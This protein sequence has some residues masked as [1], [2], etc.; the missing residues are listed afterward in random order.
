VALNLALTAAEDG[1]RVLLIDADIERAALSKTL[2]AAA[3][4]VSSI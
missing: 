1:W 4:P 3:T 2:D